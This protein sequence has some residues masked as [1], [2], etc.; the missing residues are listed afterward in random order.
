MPIKGCQKLTKLEYE[1]ESDI[2]Q[3][4]YKLIYT[5]SDNEE[6]IQIISDEFEA[7][8]DFKMLSEIVD[9]IRVT[10][11]DKKPLP[12]PK[13]NDYTSN[14]EK[15]IKETIENYEEG[16]EVESLLKHEQSEQSEE[17]QI[18]IDEVDELIEDDTKE[19]QLH[20]EKSQSSVLIH[21]PKTKDEI[22]EELKKVASDR[23]KA[24]TKPKS[25]KKVIKRVSSDDDVDDDIEVI[26][27]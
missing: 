27:L 10:K 2:D 11:S 16:S 18:N 13:V 4:L 15:R 1:Y 5:G 25:S 8:F 24:Q 9:I 26:N 6:K 22:Q 17:E 21:A 7:V 20:I 23:S 12:Q 14:V 19:S 3:S